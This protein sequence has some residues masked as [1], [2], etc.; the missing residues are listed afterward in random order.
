MLRSCGADVAGMSA[1][2][3][4]IVARHCGMKVVG[5]SVV[6]GASAESWPSVARAAAPRIDRIV[7]GILKE[8]RRKETTRG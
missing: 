7:R 2:A 8:S 4:T 1:V 5:I 6:D 3:E